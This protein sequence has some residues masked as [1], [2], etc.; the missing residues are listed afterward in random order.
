MAKLE[1]PFT[2]LFTDQPLEQEIKK[3]NEHGEMVGLSR[4]E[5]ALDRL[6]IITPHLARLVNQYLSG[7]P[8]ASR[9]SVRREHYQ[10]S[11]EIALRSRANAP[12][13]QQTI[14][15]HCEGNPFEVNTPLKSLVSSALVSDETKQD[16]LQFTEKG[17]KCFEEFISQHLM[18]TWSL[19]V[20]DK[21]K[22]LKLKAFS[23]W[24]E[25]ATVHVG[26]KVVKLREERELLGRFLIIQAS[27]P[28]LVPKLE[29][30]IG[31]Y[32]MSTV[33]WSLCAAD[34]SLFI[35]TDKASFM[36]AVEDAKAESLEDAPQPEL[37]QEPDSS[38]N[39][40]I[41]DAMGV[42][43]SIKKTPTMLKLSDLPDAFNKRIEKMVVG[44]DEG[45]VVFDRY[46]DQ[47]L[48]NKTK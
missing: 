25:K 44:Y 43:Q 1:I 47:S 22:K 21:M 19:S 32:E 31:E 10:L 4:D 9:S 45:R 17:Q 12:K 34:G 15:L 36:H 26:D 27:R 41:V 29:E 18:S 39:V 46:M 13:I 23:N 14:E 2:R 20:R 37:I 6:V 3:L 30:T 28:S 5:A 24:M 7:F 33:P 42:L 40:L 16:I 8:K 48:K 38:V 35:P 11:G